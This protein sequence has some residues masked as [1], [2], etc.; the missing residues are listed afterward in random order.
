MGTAG[1][2][3]KTGNRARLETIVKHRSRRYTI[4]AQQ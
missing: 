3:E 4:V 2:A 1:K